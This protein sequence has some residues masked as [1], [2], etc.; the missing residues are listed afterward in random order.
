MVFL[1]RDT[2]LRCI[3]WNRFRRDR[4]RGRLRSG[5]R[6]GIL[7]DTGIWSRLAGGRLR[8]CRGSRIS[9]SNSPTIAQG[10]LKAHELTMR[11]RLGGRIHGCF[12]RGLGS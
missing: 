8:T 1:G 4:R 2:G 7:N 3:C 6:C 5:A 12:V 10:S 9:Y 11:F